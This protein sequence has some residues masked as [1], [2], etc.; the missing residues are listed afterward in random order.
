MF[1][2]GDQ[3]AI[4]IVGTNKQAFPAEEYSTYPLHLFRYKKGMFFSTK[5]IFDSVKFVWGPS[6][7]AYK[8]FRIVNEATNGWMD[9]LFY[10]GRL[11]NKSESF[12]YRAVDCSQIPATVI[13]LSGY[14]VK[15]YY[16]NEQMEKGFED[17]EG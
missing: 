1:D 14:W 7:E 6:I 3:D 8:K 9:F 10:N 11:I 16:T 15:F 4:S 5:Q 13:N 17:Y 2:P 12:L